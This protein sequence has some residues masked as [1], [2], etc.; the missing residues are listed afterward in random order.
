MVIL[1][2]DT[3][4][5]VVAL[6]GVTRLES[7]WSDRNKTIA[8]KCKNDITGVYTDNAPVK[9]RHKYSTTKYNTLRLYR[10]IE[11]EEWRSSGGKISSYIYDHKTRHVNVMISQANA[12]R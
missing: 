3:M 9:Q 8:E 12:L 7:Q 1:L 6:E 5:K 4:T 11:R 10:A 2:V